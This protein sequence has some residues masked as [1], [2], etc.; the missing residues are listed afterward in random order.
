[1][2]HVREQWA[3]FFIKIGFHVV[4]DKMKVM[5]QRWIETRRF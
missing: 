2:G 1:M 4:M 5:F 3:P